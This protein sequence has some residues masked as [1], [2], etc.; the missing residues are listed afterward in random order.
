MGEKQR[1]W[2]V[3][4]VFYPEEVAT[5]YIMTEIALALSKQKEVHVICGPETYERKKDNIDYSKVKDLKLHRINSFNLNK[6]KLHTRLLRF[7]GIAMGMFFK[8][9]WQIKKEDKVFIVTN[10]APLIPLYALLKWL[11]GFELII[12]VHD[13]F[14]EN[15][16]TGKMI[17]PSN[18]LYKLLK[19][20]FDKSYKKADTLAVLGRDMQDVMVQKTGLPLSRIPITPNWADLEHVSEQ[21]F[22]ANP[23]IEKHHLQD[24]IVIQYAG[25]HG[26][27]Q[28]L[29]EFLEVVNEVKNSNLHFV[30]VGNGAVKKQMQAFAETNKLDN[31]SFWEPFS[32]PEQNVYLNACHIGLVTLS[33]EL[34]GLGVPS[35]SYNILASGRPV[36]FLGNKD[37][38][39]G[40]TIVEHQC[41]WVF[42]HHQKQAIVDFLNSLTKDSLA[43]IH[44]KG[45]AGKTLAITSYAKPI[46]LRQFEE[47]VFQ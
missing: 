20:I 4:E 15:M 34:Y 14:P 26:R 2:M 39:I 25:N 22:E 40:K 7:I 43:V 31:V 28:H 45:H 8:G 35:K 23:I 16:V 10:P 13:V 6:N 17:K 36:L 33:D 47:I 27:L 37:T 3:S 30:F 1:L 29:P 41:G 18:P 38:E 9:L 42:G 19:R 32:R 24:K 12:L 46:I 21:P 11:K 44:D 5:G